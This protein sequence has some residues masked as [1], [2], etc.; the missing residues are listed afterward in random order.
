MDWLRQLNPEKFV[1][2]TLVLTRISGLVMTAPIYGTKDVPRQV[3]VLLALALALLVMP[4][5]WNAAVDWPGSTIAYLVLV[6]GELLVGVCLGLG[7]VVLLSGVQLAGEMIGRVGGLMLADVF[8]PGAEANVPLFSRLMFL[9]TLAVFVCIGGH[10]VVMAGLLDTFQ[11]IP[12]GGAAMSRSIVDAFVVVLTQS[13]ALG[14]RACMPV[15]TAL[16]LSTLV[17]GLISRTLPQLNILMVG[18]GLNSMLAF[19][20]L[21]LTLGAAAWAFQAQIEPALEA[22]LDALHAPLRAEWLA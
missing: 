8:D 17:M 10:R 5:Q 14:V 18:F 9:V 3:R 12:L 19:A 1:L 2:F 22:V 20:V 6:G 15:V 4:S 16:L 13:F 11:T 7:I 21:A